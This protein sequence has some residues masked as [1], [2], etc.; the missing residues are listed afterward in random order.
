[1]PGK[2][3]KQ[4]GK[5]DMERKRVRPE[6]LLFFMLIA[7]VALAGG[8]SD[9]VYANY[10]KEVY[11]VSATRRAFIE[12]PRELPGLLCVLA[13][14]LL[15]GLGDFRIAVIA[16]VCACAGLMCLGLITPP[17]GVMLIFLFINS[18]GMHLFMPVSDSLGM[19]LAEPDK[20]GRRMGQY[21]SVKTAMGFLAGIVVFLGFRL[22]WFSFGARV[23]SIFII[24]AALYAVAILAAVLLLKKAGGTG[25][26][27]PVKQR[28]RIIFRREYK[29]YY[30]LTVLS[31]VQKQIAFVF[32]SWVLIDLLGKGADV[33][34]LLTIA[35]SFLGIFFMGLIGRWMD[36][37]GIRAMMYVDALTFIGVYV[38]YGF[39]VMGITSGRL[40]SGGWAVLLVYALFVMDRLSMQVGV[41]KSVYLRSI[42]VSGDEV[43]RT[44]STGTSMD[45]LV[46]IVAAQLSGLVWTYFGPCWVFF[47]AA[48]FS[49][50]NLFVAWRIKPVRQNV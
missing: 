6:L 10:Y 19:S 22:G 26:H 29:Y 21:G 1:M 13:V 7:A 44:L 32:G 15:S 46:S 41:V 50:G 36:R 49:L 42:A 8:M 17:F 30:L 16:Q 12:F 31:G 47:I 43:T 23:K 24:G 39:V 48:A 28:F 5:T 9:S 2:I 34:S 38:M 40:P 25:A 27:M 4:R 14:S 37:F 20:I 33:M 45:H 18:F 35:S 3:H 11:S